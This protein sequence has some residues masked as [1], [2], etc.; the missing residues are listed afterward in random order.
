MLDLDFSLEH[1]TVAATG[2]ESDRLKDIAR[3]VLEQ[4]GASGAWT[5]AVA[6]VSDEH[7]Q[8]LHFDFMGVDEAT[9]VM[10]FPLSESGGEQGGDI[11]ISVDH[12]LAHGTEWGNSPAEEIE[13]LMVHGLLHL[14][15][16]RDEDDGQRTEMLLRQEEIL[17]GYREDEKR[18]PHLYLS[19]NQLE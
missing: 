10:T 14:M 7:L 2:T 11:A 6:L 13:F 17:Q 16:W 9:D 8:R 19:S 18:P 4:Q 15:G 12:A 3:Y 5:V 1:M